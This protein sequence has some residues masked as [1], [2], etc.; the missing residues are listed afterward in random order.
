MM[1]T[2]AETLWATAAGLSLGLMFYG[3]LWWTVSRIGDFRRPALIVLGS[4]LLRTAAVLWG[5]YSVSA[6]D[7]SRVL[8][9]L[10]GF[11]VA[12]LAVTWVTRYPSPVKSAA[13]RHAP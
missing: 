12:R 2:I 4:A 7:L 1:M 5:F 10:L 6:N 9:C 8:M 11:L 3:G 13:V